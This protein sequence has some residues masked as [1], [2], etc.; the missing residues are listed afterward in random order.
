MSQDSSKLDQILPRLAR[1]LDLELRHAT[2]ES[3]GFVLLVFPDG[4]AGPARLVSNA[5]GTGVK[6][7]L[8]LALQRFSLDGDGEPLEHLH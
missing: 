1:M 3:T 2:G 7:A 4:R 6:T 8:H 5:G